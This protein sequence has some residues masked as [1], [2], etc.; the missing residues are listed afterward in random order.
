VLLGRESECRA[1]DELLEVQAGA[2]RGAFGLSAE[3]LE[4]RFLVSAAMLGQLT[5]AKLFVSPK[6][7]EYHLR[8]VFAKLGIASRNELIRIDLGTLT[9]PE[10]PA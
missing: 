10:Q 9:A 7:V 3:R 8:K 4:D 5:A 1:I 2:L 6:T